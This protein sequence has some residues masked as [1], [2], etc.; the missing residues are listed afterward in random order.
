MIHIT[1]VNHASFVASVDGVSLICDPWLDGMVFDNGWSLLSE[2][3]FKYDDFAR[4]T[5]V[6]FSHEHPDH[7]NPPNLRKIPESY[8]RKIT[9]LFHETRD[10]RVVKLCKSFGFQTQELPEDTWVHLSDKVDV[11]CG[12]QGMIDSWLAIRADG[13]TIL[14][15]NDCVF[16]RDSELEHVASLV[17]SPNVLF[18]QFSYANW[19]GNPQDYGS[20]RR[21]A[22]AKLREIARQVRALQP[23]VVVPC[24]SFV[25]FSHVENYFANREANRIWDVYDFITQQLGVKTVVLYPGD[26]W[27][28]G[29]V[30]TDSTQALEKYRL[31]YTAVENS[32]V[33]LTKSPPV[34][35]ER[36]HE[37]HQSLRRKVIARNKLYL[38]RMIPSTIVFLTDLNVKFTISLLRGIKVVTDDSS[39]ADIA[40]SSEALLYCFSYDWGGDTLAVNGRFIA[41]EGGNR[42]R[43]FRTFRVAA[44]NA[45]GFTLDLLVLFKI[46]KRFVERKLGLTGFKE[47]PA[48]SSS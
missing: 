24:A 1:W 31:D 36:L 5:H 27:M 7:F 40:L 32:R 48:A 11:L 22:R 28:V 15:M 10:K 37:A 44:Y 45:A 12:R 47:S 21:Y 16:D 30:G 38:L 20:H 26:Q 13:Q 34:T 3:K 39:I 8:R 46:A 23:K 42:L 17:G 41:P 4:I 25:W 6:F 14:N 33:H 19:V 18:T 29:D 2:T 9:V 35:L 43:F